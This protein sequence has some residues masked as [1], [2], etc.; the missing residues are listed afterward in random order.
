MSWDV[1][2]AKELKKRNN[3][4]TIGPQIGEVISINPIKVSIYNNRVIL[5]NSNSYRCSKLEVAPGDK[6][7]CLPTSNGQT[8][9]IVDKVV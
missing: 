1:E 7:L 9:F 8:F 2:L 4:S 6:V 3:P 5:T